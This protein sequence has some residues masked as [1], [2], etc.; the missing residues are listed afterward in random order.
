[1][2]SIIQ[3]DGKEDTPYIYANPEEGL[4]EI[5]GR[6]L[7]EEP[8]EFYEPILKWV[9]EYLESFDKPLSIKFWFEYFNT[10][11]AKQIFLILENLDKFYQKGKKIDLKWYVSASEDP[12]DSP[13]I[14][15]LVDLIEIPFEVVE[16]F[17]NGEKRVTPYNN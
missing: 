7:P 17:E 3:L 14:E 11:S 16:V 5:S 10:S 9:L 15:E 1:M 2:L 6:S 13:V 8:I 4:L 12:D